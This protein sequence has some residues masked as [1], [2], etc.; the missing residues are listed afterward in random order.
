MSAESWRYVL[1]FISDTD[2]LSFLAFFFNWSCW[3]LSSLLHFSRKQ[4]LLYWFS[5]LIHT[6]SPRQ[7]FDNLF[8]FIRMSHSFA[9]GIII[10]M[11]GCLSLFLLYLCFFFPAF[12]LSN[13]FYFLLI[14]LILLV[15]WIT[16]YINLYY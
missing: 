8:L 2:N 4:L 15:W 12:L 5:P 7:E 6:F 3:D 9:F 11:V 1:F 10:D 13:H 16:L 14:C